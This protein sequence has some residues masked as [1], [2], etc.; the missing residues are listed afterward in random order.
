MEH[1]IT[2]IADFFLGLGYSGIFAMMFLEASFFPF[3]SEVA[4][5]PAGYLVAQGTMNPIL[6]LIAGTLGSIGGASLN[7]ILGKYAGHAF[8]IK[9]GKYLFIDH[10]KIDEMTDLFQRKGTF[11]VFFGRLIPVVRQYI[12]FPPGVA[13]MPYLKFAFFTGL[14]SAI[15]V[16]FL[17]V[18]GYF[19][20]HNSGAINGILAK[21]K[22][23]AIIL[24]LLFFCYLLKKK[25][26]KKKN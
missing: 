26:S 13:N 1:F 18:L 21:F 17:E 15:W 9:Y 5:L 6:V 4:I 22:I 19:Y 11:I 8:L 20:G 16:A 12:S 23:T 2:I 24:V 25:L 3:P 14:G 7:Y 10:K